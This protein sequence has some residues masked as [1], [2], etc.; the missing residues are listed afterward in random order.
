MK[1][2][3]RLLLLTAFT[4]VC[5][6]AFA[7]A[8]ELT[9]ECG[10]E[11]S[12]LTWALDLDT[13]VLTISGEGAMVDRN[14]PWSGYA[15]MIRT[16]I[17][18]KGVTSIGRSAFDDYNQITRVE[19]P[20]GVTKIGAFAFLWCSNL[21]EL[22]LPATVQEIGFNALAMTGQ[23]AFVVGRG[24]GPCPRRGGGDPRGCFR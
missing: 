11:G 10:A 22:V 16:V 9:G 20:E 14:M 3:F 19:I 12:N 1:K 7:S 17:M 6:C 4:A 5:L 15:S 8:E 23:T 2:I 21:T 18:E 13:G 24:S